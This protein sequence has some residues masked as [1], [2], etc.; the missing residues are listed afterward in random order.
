MRYNVLIA[1]VD[2]KQLL[3][4]MSPSKGSDLGIFKAHEVGKA[5]RLAFNP[6]TLR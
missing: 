1:N 4:N 6:L 5:N 3:D 2:F